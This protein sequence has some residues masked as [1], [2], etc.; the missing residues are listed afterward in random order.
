MSTQLQGQS[1]SGGV[2]AGVDVQVD[3]GST[4]ADNNSNSSG[5]NFVDAAVDDGEHTVVMSDDTILA[6]T[7][8]QDGR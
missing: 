8:T 7:S 5:S 2:S 4:T 6:A 3:H 1:S